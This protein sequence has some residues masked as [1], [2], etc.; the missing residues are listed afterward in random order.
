MITIATIKKLEERYP[1]NAAELEVLIRCHDKLCENDSKDDFLTVLAKA[2][3]Y[4]SFF[5]PGDEMSDRVDWIEEHILPM[6]FSSRLRCALATDSFVD[7]ANQGENRVLERLIEG[8]AKT[9]RRGTVESLNVTFGVLDEDATAEGLVELCLSMAIASECLVVP[10]LDKKAAAQRLQ[11]AKPCILSMARS[12][13]SFCQ[14]KKLNKRIFVDWA[15]LK[16]PLLSSTLSSFVH[17]LL[18]HGHAYPKTRVQYASPKIYET[19]EIFRKE[20][21]PLLLSLSFSNTG[22]GGKVCAKFSSSICLSACD[23]CSCYLI[24]PCPRPSFIAPNIVA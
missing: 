5:L 19:S 10:N 4:S 2:L 18:F 3:P 6:G 14:G 15:E 11:D 20:T 21:S 22:F 16:F 24:P 7:Y 1:F 17:N 8:I 9:G 13:T 23:F 12:L